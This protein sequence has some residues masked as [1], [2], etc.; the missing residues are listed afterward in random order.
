MVK[1]FIRSSLLLLSLTV[2]FSMDSTGQGLSEVLGLWA[3]STLAD[4]NTA[5]EIEY[6]NETEKEVI[7][8][9]NLARTSPNFFN[10]TIV[11]YYLNSTKSK[12]DK[13]VKE[14]IATLETTSAMPMLEPR[15]D[16]WK[17]AKS[18]A[19]DMGK[20]GRTGH[21]SSDGTTFRDRMSVFSQTYQSVNENCNYGLESALDIVMDLLIDRE[22]SNAGHRKNIL[23]PDSR[24]IGVSVQ[25]H[26]RYGT[27]CVQDFAGPR[28]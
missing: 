22:I 8:Y 27:N 6:L 14:L 16:L 26:K 11:D 10:E 20:T 15:E 13:Y 21:N 12:K 23:N 5:K 9:I 19:T 24:F 2:A 25:P 3:D 4:A 7:F 1:R 28:L 18:H 17:S